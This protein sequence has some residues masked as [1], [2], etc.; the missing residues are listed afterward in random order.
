MTEKRNNTRP[1]EQ[2]PLTL[3]DP[4]LS[5]ESQHSPTDPSPITY[6]PLSER[7]YHT[8]ATNFLYELISAGAPPDVSDS[9]KAM[10]ELHLVSNEAVLMNTNYMAF[11]MLMMSEDELAPEIMSIIER[12]KKSMASPSELILLNLETNMPSVELKKLTHPYGHRSEHLEQMDDDVARAIG[13]HGGCY[14]PT[15]DIDTDLEVKILPRQN[16]PEGFIVTTRERVG[17]VRELHIRK[18]KTFAVNVMSPEF[19]ARIRSK[20]KAIDSHLPR[21]EWIQKVVTS[22]G[23]REYVDA[24]LLSPYESPYL[25]GLSTMIYSYHPD[26]KK[27]KTKEEQRNAQSRHQLHLARHAI[28]AEKAREDS[29]RLEES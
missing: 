21:D 8:D 28:A 6:M 4:S 14:Y 7:I 25:Y 15:L 11:Q 29:I 24:A 10:I 22:T 5:P 1:D 17:T 23:L 2:S 19:D 16:D 13:H 27:P 12:A 20:I 9:L 3:V 18:R 26:R